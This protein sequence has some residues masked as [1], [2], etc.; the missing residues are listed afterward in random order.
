V[1]PWVD[2][3][4]DETGATIIDL[5]KPLAGKQELFPDGVHPNAAGA[6]RIAKTIAAAITK[7]T[8]RKAG[9]ENG[10]DKN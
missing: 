5:Y 6:E 8:S 1:I 3:V 4:A 9:K 7:E 2:R 10:K